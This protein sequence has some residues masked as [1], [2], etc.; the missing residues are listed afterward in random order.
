MSG[1]YVHA[2]FPLSLWLHCICIA[3]GCSAKVKEIDSNVNDGCSLA[4]LVTAPWNHI[5][6]K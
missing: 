6:M 2:C 5:L 1:L 4:C 3:T